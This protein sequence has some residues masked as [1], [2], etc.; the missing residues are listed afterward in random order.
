MIDVELLIVGV[1]IDFTYPVGTIST[2]LGLKVADLSS[3]NN[4]SLNITKNLT[5][6]GRSPPPIPCC[7]ARLFL[8]TFSTYVLCY[9][10]LFCKTFLIFC[11]GVRHFM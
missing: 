11:V 5:F 10:E 6:K 2:S 8:F 4:L 1:G 9:Y 7:S 3:G